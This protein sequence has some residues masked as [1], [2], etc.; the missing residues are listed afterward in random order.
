MSARLVA[1]VG[2]GVAGLACAR[3]LRAAGR[4]VVVFDKGR[5]PGGRVSTRRQ[6]GLQFDHG[7]QFFTA[8]DPRFLGVV[9]R[10]EERGSVARW[11]GPFATLQQGFRGDDPRAGAVRYV[12]AP[13]M[14]GLAHALTGEHA[15][16]SGAHVA[17]VL[18]HEG[19]FVLEL[20][21]QEASAA[22]RE[23]PFDEVVVAVPPRQAAD[24]LE[25]VGGDALR[26]AE[27]LSGA[28][29]PS[30]CAMVAFDAALPGAE[31]GM[32]VVDDEV[33]GWAAHDG[34]KPGRGDAPT[35]VL[36]GTAAWSLQNYQRA[37]EDFAQDLLGA[38]GRA[39]GRAGGLPAPTHLVGHRWG[40]ALADGEPP[41]EKFVLEPSGLGLCGDALGGGRVEGAFVSGLELGDALVQR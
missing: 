23:G 14:S 36:H 24:L 41:R 30:L 16:E 37:P 22:S 33:L 35:Y 34:G 27:Q 7:A 8:R 17:R 2:A 32:F 11:P 39:L 15:V 25:D 6:G 3:R 29:L 40:Y 31:G 4:H 10:C 20:R 18:G 28:L 38:F 12:G 26:A 21:G 1:V 19:G 9:A 5:R 13:G